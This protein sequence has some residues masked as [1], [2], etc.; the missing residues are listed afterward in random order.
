MTQPTTDPVVYLA[1]SE[2]CQRWRIDARTLDKLDLAWLWITPRVRRISM[3]AVVQFEQKNGW[4][5]PSTG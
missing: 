5:R 3:Q 1:P 4:D 2:L